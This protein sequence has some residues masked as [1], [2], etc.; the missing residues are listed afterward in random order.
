MLFISILFTIKRRV[1]V[2]GIKKER[3]PGVREIVVEIR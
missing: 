1:N 3:C 2:K